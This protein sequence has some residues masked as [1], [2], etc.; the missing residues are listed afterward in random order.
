MQFIDIKEELERG[1][2]GSQ[3]R[4]VYG[5][6]IFSVSTTYLF[7]NCTKSS[8]SKDHNLKFSGVI[9]SFGLVHKLTKVVFVVILR[10]FLTVPNRK[11]NEV[12]AANFRIF[13][14]ISIAAI[15]FRSTEM[16]AHSFSRLTLM[17]RKLG[18]TVNTG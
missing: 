17:T 7:L 16:P 12:N 13:G 14:Y 4:K 10:H 8:S 15:S 11:Y 9:L 18:V 3:H 2:F 5:A 6:H 1:K